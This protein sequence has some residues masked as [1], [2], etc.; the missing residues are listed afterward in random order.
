[1]LALIA[2]LGGLLATAPSAAGGAIHGTFATPA[3]LQPGECA[4]VIGYSV[5]NDWWRAGFEE[6]PGIDEASWEAVFVFGDM[7]PRWADP[8][9]PGWTGDVK[10]GI[11][12]ASCDG[13]PT[14]LVVQIAHLGFEEASNREMLDLLRQVIDNAREHYPDLERID[15]IPIVG[16]PRHRRCP[17]VMAT[18]MHPRMD[19]I[20][21]S[22]VDGNLVFAGP[23]L[24]ASSCRDF[25]DAT[26]H[27]SDSGASHAA[28]VMARRFGG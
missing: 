12:S 18:R 21:A 25:R 10:R 28:N 6:L 20:I 13:S 19:A 8:D 27:L 2:V 23:D 7:L 22:A 9:F 4:R 24:R 11:R 16:G 5:T 17:G 26:G 14:R 3:G 1:V 15:L